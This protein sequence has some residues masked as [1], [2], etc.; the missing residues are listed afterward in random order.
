MY[1]I[2][3]S[4]SPP[5]HRK[6]RASVAFATEC[7]RINKIRR[8]NRKIRVPIAMWPCKVEEK[9]TL[10]EVDGK[11]IQEF[12]TKIIAKDGT[13]T[14][15]PG[16]FQGY[17]TSEKSRGN[18]QGTRKLVEFVN[19]PQ[20][21][22]GVTRNEFANHVDLSQRMVLNMNDVLYSS[23]S[24]WILQ[25][26]LQLSETGS[27][28]QGL[29]LAR[30]RQVTRWNFNWLWRAAEIT[31]AMENSVE[32]GALNGE[33]S[34]SPDFSS[35]IYLICAP[36]DVE[37]YHSESC[38]DVVLWEMDWLSQHKA[39]IVCH[40]KV[41]EIPVEDGRILRVHGERAVGI[42]KALKSAKEDEPK[43]TTY[44]YVPISFSALLEMQKNCLAGQSYK[45]RVSLT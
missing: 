17:E 44:P 33:Y 4:M 7:R 38:F 40:K 15:V 34:G 37:D 9:M 19:H 32:E 20:H 39:V 25:I 31:E 30:L 29:S 21:S 5:I 45:T 36:L 3:C 18:D 41:V 6:Y 27:F 10:K 24:K 14:R 43:L 2:Y 22:K 12:E 23:P 28:C 42:T 35:H 26:V 16:T 1:V 8:G 13:I 11:T